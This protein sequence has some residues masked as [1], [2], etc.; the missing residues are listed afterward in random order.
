MIFPRLLQLNSDFE[1]DMIIPG[2][3]G[4]KA[5]RAYTRTRRYD[6]RREFLSYD[7]EKNGSLH[8]ALG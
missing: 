1:N 8:T 5:G 2:F 4:K 7:C 6:T 3:K